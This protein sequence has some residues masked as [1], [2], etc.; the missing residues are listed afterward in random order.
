MKTYRDPV[1]LRPDSLDVWLFSLKSS[2]A[3]LK[4]FRR[5]LSGDETNRADRFLFDRDRCHFT[6]ARARLRQILGRY[7]N[8]NPAAIE[9]RYGEYGKPFLA[10]NSGPD[11][12]LFNLSHSGELGLFCINR[13]RRI[14]ADIEF[15]R[16][17]VAFRQL[18]KRFFS[19]SEAEGLERA[20]SALLKA[21]FYRIWTSKEAYIKAIGEGLSMPLDRFDVEYRVD[22]PPALLRTRPDSSEASRW[23]LCSIACQKG[24]TATVAI[25]QDAVPRRYWVEAADGTFHRG[26]SRDR[27]SNSRPGN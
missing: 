8:R 4:E 1:H 9:F 20:D 16:Q 12:I 25:E 26:C 21:M 15:Q 19:Q 24:Y 17:N 14:G 13:G 22:H 23:F 11:D 6:V 3:A 10:L 7:L 5:C 2:Q 27:Q 18:A